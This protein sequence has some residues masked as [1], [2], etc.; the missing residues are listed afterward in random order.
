MNDKD[1]NRYKTAFDEGDIDTLEKLRHKH[2]EDS[3]FNLHLQVLGIKPKLTQKFDDVR[4]RHTQVAKSLGIDGLAGFNKLIE[5]DNKKKALAY[6]DSL[7]KDHPLRSAMINL[8]N[9]MK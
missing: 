1:L 9:F 2:P 4:Q 8:T 3:R 6:I 5:S 7:R